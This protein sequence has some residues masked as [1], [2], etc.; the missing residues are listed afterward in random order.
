LV[1][2][3]PEYR[4][5]A[6]RTIAYFT[7]RK[8][9]RSS[10]SA[11]PPLLLK[12]HDPKRQRI[13]DRTSVENVF[14]ILPS[15]LLPDACSV[16]DHTLDLVE[17]RLKELLQ[18]VKITQEMRRKRTVRQADKEMKQAMI[19]SPFRD[20]A[21]FQDDTDVDST[22]IPTRVLR[23]LTMSGFLS[24][25]DLGRLLLLTSKSLL[26][27]LG[28]EFTYYY[29]CRN[30]WRNSMSIPSIVK[31]KGYTWLYKR[32]SEGLQKTNSRTW[33]AI[34]QP[35]LSV[36]NLEL[37]VNVHD[38]ANE[39]LSEVLRGESLGELFRC[40]R[41][42][43]S[44]T[45]PVL[46]GDFPIENGF[47]KSP[48]V[49]FEN[50]SAT[51]HA[52]RLD[53]KSCRCV[54]Q[55]SDVWWFFKGDPENLAGNLHFSPE[56]VGLE[57][58]D[59]GKELE[60]RI[61]EF[62]R[63]MNNQPFEGIYFEATVISSFSRCPTDPNKTRFSFSKLKVEIWSIYEYAGD[64]YHSESESKTHGVTALHLLDKLEGL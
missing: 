41:T 12:M 15:N 2:L 58:T 10:A 42:Y 16:D 64:V 32:L 60:S 47:I 44:L 14:H 35:T 8:H 30:R 55:S 7:A 17:T 6:N 25:G 19:N 18:S 46:I 9:R 31:D 34:Q 13:G 20:G 59:E 23:Q 49:D 56:L 24:A 36:D 21:A 61:R 27:D 53:K 3:F 43:V 63:V 37:M 28:E 57:L 5:E 11:P 4:R 45:K 39:K 22:P 52:V 33:G 38:G 54:H 40:G 26:I 51:M 1:T 50:W 48:T 29:L 62:D